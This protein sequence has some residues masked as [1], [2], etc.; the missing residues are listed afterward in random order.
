M[1]RLEIDGHIKNASFFINPI[2]LDSKKND[3][4]NSIKRVHRSPELPKTIEKLGFFTK[5][6]F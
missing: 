4:P 1:N 3:G 5:S 2:P 6:F